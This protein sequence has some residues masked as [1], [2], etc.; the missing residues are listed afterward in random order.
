[1]AVVISFVGVKGGAGK[2]TLAQSIAAEWTVRGFRVLLICLDKKQRSSEKWAAKRAKF[3]HGEHGPTVFGMTENIVV[4]FARTV[5]AYDLVIIDTRADLG[6]L[7]VKALGLSDLALMPCGPNGIEV[8]AMEET[9]A[10][11]ASVRRKR[12]E[13]D[14]LVIITRKQPNTVVGREARQAYVGTGFDVCRVELEFALDFGQAYHVGQGPTEWKPKSKAADQTR[15]LCDALQ[16]RLKIT[17]PRRKRAVR[18]QESAP[19]KAVRKVAAR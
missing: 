19:G 14:A 17:A 4:N 11:V 8:D 18:E 1:V 15:A 2:S 13:L 10:E 3:G 9:F 5:A 6:D 12:P 7:P 16:K